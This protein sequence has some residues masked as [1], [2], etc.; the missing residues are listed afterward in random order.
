MDF[1]RDYT[2]EELAKMTSSEVNK[3]KHEKTK[4]LSDEIEKNFMDIGKIL[5]Y[6][7]EIKKY[8]EGE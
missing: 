6:Q 3:I 5:F 2:S 8:R 7:T 4:Q 1:K